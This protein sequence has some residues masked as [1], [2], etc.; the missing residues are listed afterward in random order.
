[1]SHDMYDELEMYAA[2]ERLREYLWTVPVYDE[3]G[4]RSECEDHPGQ[5]R[6][7]I[8][9]F[10]MDECVKRSGM[11]YTAEEYVQAE[12]MLDRALQ[13]DPVTRGR[14]DRRFHTLKALRDAASAAELDPSE[15]G[16][17][18]PAA[19]AEQLG[20]SEQEA[21]REMHI[22]LDLGLVDGPQ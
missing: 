6:Y 15:K 13:F 10:G 18:V 14:W 16:G 5:F 17:L 20:I 4:Q 21:V 7:S 2:A 3:Y 8:T 12:E 11:S 19:L 9:P 22:L 1:M